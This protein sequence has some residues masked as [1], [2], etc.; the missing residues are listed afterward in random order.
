MRKK[1]L[2]VISLTLF[3]ISLPVMAD[4]GWDSD[5]SSGGGS[6]NSWSSSDRY[7][8]SSYR[9]HD[10]HSSSQ[11][12]SSAVSDKGIIFFFLLFAGAGAGIVILNIL[13]HKSK[14][15]FA[16]E[17]NHTDIVQSFFPQYTEKDLS[18]LL[19]QKF[20]DIQKAWM[21]FDYESLKK[22]CSMELFESYK[23]DLE[24]L[25]L[26]KGQNVMDDFS[27]ISASIRDIH[28][29][30]DMIVIEMYLRT[31]FYDYVINVEDQ[32]IIR[33]TSE[34]KI[35]NHYILKYA[36]SSTFEKEACPSCG[37]LVSSNECPYCHSFVKDRMM[38]F[39]LIS[40][41]KF[42]D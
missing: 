39:V 26:K 10:T 18:L 7:S 40:K 34:Q 23:A 11:K 35:Q 6:G 38:D 37:A 33:G 12:R 32:S 24:V 25:K 19:Y 3:C 21:N 14:P 27:C 4:S 15:S 1:L 30:Q 42:E 28:K 22:L 8:G 29:E 36:I 20:V 16:K 41:K 5:Y 9:G 31:S 17:I 13:S 2:C